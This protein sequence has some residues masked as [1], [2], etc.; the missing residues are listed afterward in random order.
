MR[1]TTAAVCL[2]VLLAGCATLQTKTEN[3][4]HGANYPT[5]NNQH[6]QADVLSHKWTFT[7]GEIR[8]ITQRKHPVLGNEVVCAEPAPDVALALSTA[9]GLAG[10]GGS[11]TVTAGL[12][13]SSA[14]AEAVAELAG[15]STALLGLR[16]G[17]YRACEAYANGILGQGTYALVLSRYSQLMSTLFLAQD[18]TG[19]AGAASKGATTNSVAVQAPNLTAPTGAGA[20]SSAAPAAPAASSPG[21]AAASKTS[22]VQPALDVELAPKLVPATFNLDPEPPAKLIRVADSATGTGDTTGGGGGT[23]TSKGAGAGA[24]TSDA[25]ATGALSLVRMNEDFLHQGVVDLLIT[26]C[27]NEFDPTRLRPSRSESDPAPAARN[28][29]G[30][31]AMY[32][33]PA[34]GGGA[35][36][37]AADQQKA[38][39]AAT[40]AA[41]AGSLAA[42]Q[43][44]VYQDQVNAARAAN[45][46]AMNTWLEN[47]CDS[48][49]GQALIKI[50][51]ASAELNKTYWAPVNPEAAVGGKPATSANNTTTPK[52]DD[53]KTAATVEAV[54]KA[55][56]KLDCAGCKGLK[57]DGKM[58]PKTVRAV[59]SYQTT[60]KLT[61]NGDAL[62]PATVAKL[63]LQPPAAKAAG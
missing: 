24:T 43:A 13:M 39:A 12:N 32:V 58:G 55:L 1:G 7:T 28:G 11:G 25:S 52:A 56:A 8:L 10:Q 21:S 34:A 57:A 20:A 29:P 15:R 60:N 51:A 42:A 30:V 38:A 2:S 18:V 16:D 45:G 63:G 27:I 48:I 26:S 3:G 37:S 36:Q 31:D 61:V 46:A 5:E 47:L 53:G 6:G 19:A 62:D 54:Q 33:M 44:Q 59:T 4:Y 23:D 17:L 22:Q 35:A 9:A 49:N 50:M 41:A 14:S 40:A